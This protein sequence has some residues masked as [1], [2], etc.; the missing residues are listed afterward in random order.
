MNIP[1]RITYIGN[2]V[3]LNC[4]NIESI[5][6]EP[7]NQYYNSG[8]NSN[9]LIETETARLLQ[10]CKNSVIPDGVKIIAR[11]AFYQMPISYISIP[12]TVEEIGT[13]AFSSTGLEYI[14]IP[15]SVTTIGHEAF[16]GI[17]DFHV[18]EGSYAWDYIL[19]EYPY[20]SLTVGKPEIKTTIISQPLNTTVPEGSIALFSVTAIGEDLKYQWQYCYAGETVWNDFA[21]ENSSLISVEYDEIRDGMRLRCLIKDITNKLY[22]SSAVVL[23]YE[24]RD[25]TVITKQPENAEAEPGKSAAFSIEAT[26]KNLK[27]LWQ[28]KK[29]GASKWTD[30]TTKTSAAITV[31]YDKSRDGM[32]LRCKITDGNGNY[33]FSDQAVMKYNK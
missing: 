19:S 22:Y 12:E 28:Y 3:F 32:S 1:E 10:G 33:V 9:V 2:Y 14:Y 5:T 4:K 20:A 23:T 24:K 15:S 11:E 30:W 31:A 6:V 21:S 16:D 26:G 25:E 18:E 8:D 29:A 17:E 27:Y 13:R 7:E